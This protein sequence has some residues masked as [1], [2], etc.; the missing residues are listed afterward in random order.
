M[1]EMKCTI[2]KREIIVKRKNRPTLVG[3]KNCNTCFQGGEISE[4][5]YDFIKKIIKRK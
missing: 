4:I 5:L 3:K 1:S 2:C